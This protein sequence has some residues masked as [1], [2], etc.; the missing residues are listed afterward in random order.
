MQKFSNTKFFFKTACAKSSKFCLEPSCD[1]CKAP[2][3][4]DEL[5]DHIAR[6]HDHGRAGDTPS[7]DV[8]VVRVGVHALRP[9]ESQWLVGDYTGHHDHLGHIQDMQQNK[10]NPT[11]QFKNHYEGFVVLNK[12]IF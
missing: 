7:H 12:S 11:K 2:W 4:P 8:G 6:H 1:L 3:C 9:L 5:V 10:V